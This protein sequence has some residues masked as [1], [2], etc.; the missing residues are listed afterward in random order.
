MA[1]IYFRVQLW[2]LFF[3]SAREPQAVKQ[4]SQIRRGEGMQQFVDFSIS[5]VFAAVHMFLLMSL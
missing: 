5:F 4:A 2:I 3:A 1:M